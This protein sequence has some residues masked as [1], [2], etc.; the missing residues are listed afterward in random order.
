M[1]NKITTLIFL[2]AGMYAFGQNS[3]LT[4][5]ITAS[6]PDGAIIDDIEFASNGTDVVLVAANS[7]NSEFYAIDINDNDPSNVMTN[8]VT[9]ITGFQ[10]VMDDAT[11]QDGL[12]LVTFE[13][14]PISKAVYVLAKSLDEAFIIKIE[15]N[16]DLVTVLDQSNMTYSLVNW[17][18][19]DTYGSQDMTWGDNTLIITS[20]SWTLDGQ[21]AM[22][23]APFVHASETANRLTSMFKTNWGGGYFTSAPLER[24]EFASINDESRLLGVTVCAPGFSL[25]L[26]DIP[27]EGVLEVK[28]EF[29]I[30]FDPPAK[31]VYQNQDGVDYLFDLHQ[32]WGGN[33]LVRIGEDFIDGTP[34][35]AGEFN[36]DVL[37]LRDFDGEPTIG[38]DESQVKV[39]DRTFNE[40]A[41][42]NDCN[43][44]VLEDDVLKL[45]ETGSSASCLLSVEKITEKVNVSVFPNPT[46]EYINLVFESQFSD[47]ANLE[48]KLFTIDGNEVLN[49]PLTNSSTRIDLTGYS[50]GS[51]ILS[52]NTNKEVLFSKNVEIQ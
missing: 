48:V 26:A 14:N 5:P 7:A 22:V 40:I 23:E 9:E 42:W 34:I 15:N 33:S 41:Y 47:Y 35:V 52:V 4:D 36:N 17:D 50:A 51:Y 11:G 10:D 3:L 46:S 13:V 25:P 31:V 2:C 16:G 44:L 8:T 12:T 43:L 18:G 45:F 1:K 6:L 30:N 37:Y 49:Q 29:N 19:G 24:V 27:G 28:E 21:L 39:Y 32:S 38:M 20:G